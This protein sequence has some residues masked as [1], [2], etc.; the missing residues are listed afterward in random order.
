VGLE[1]GRSLLLLGRA[2]ACQALLYQASRGP[3]TAPPGGPH[4][5]CRSVRASRGLPGSQFSGSL[6]VKDPIATVPLAM[7]SASPDG[8]RRRAA[9]HWE[10]WSNPAHTFSV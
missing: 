7:G 8:R 9:H 4:A 1:R 6:R 3:R 5:G 2:A 10:L